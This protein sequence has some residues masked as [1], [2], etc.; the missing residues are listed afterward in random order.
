MSLALGIVGDQ[1]MQH[2]VEIRNAVVLLDGHPALAEASL[3]LPAGSVTV[4]RGPNGAGKT[5]LLRLL[6]GLVPLSSGYTRVFGLDVISNRSAIAESVGLLGQQS[7]LYPDLTVGENLRLWVALNRHDPEPIESVLHLIGV[8]D[9]VDQPVGALSTGQVR[10]VA[11]CALVLRRPLLWLLDE[12]HSG[13]D[14]S[15]RA[16]LDHV[17][18]QAVASGATVLIAS[19]EHPMGHLVSHTATMI[20]G[21]VADVVEAARE[22]S[23]STT[24]RPHQTLAQR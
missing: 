9:L 24:S 1:V 10:R 19:H 3:E 11:L 4:L 17:V 2:A 7:S 5:T 18:A 14:Q 20:G 16:A 13:M 6:A 23:P 8:E 21:D 12:P 22:S 15:G